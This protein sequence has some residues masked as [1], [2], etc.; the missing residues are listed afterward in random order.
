MERRIKKTAIF[1]SLLLFVT[2]R[3]NAQDNTE[4]IKLSEIIVTLQK[5]YNIQFNYAEDVIAGISLKPPQENLSLLEVL[6]YLENNTTLKFSLLNSSFV[7]VKPRNNIVLCGY[8]KSED[9]LQI[10]PF[11]TI[12][13]LN[14]STTSDKNGFFQIEINNTSQLITIRHLGYKTVTQSYNQFNISGCSDVYL[15]PEFQPLPQIIISNYITSGINKINNGSF[16]INFSDLKIL[17]GLINNDVLQAVQT[18]PGIQSINETVSNINIR[19]G[20]HD[21]NLILWDGIKMYQSGHFFGLISMYNP[22]ITQEVSLRKNGSDVS[23]TDGVSGTI[24]MHTNHEINTEFKGV[25]DLNLTDFNGFADFPVGERSSVQVAARKSI[26]DF[27]ETPTYTAFFDRI[28]Q[29]TEVESNTTAIAN[30]DKTFDFYDTSLRWLYNISAKDKVRLNFINV[31]NQLQFN[32]NAII[33]Q[34]VVSRNSKLT[35]NSIAGALQYNRLWNNKLS[36]DLEIYETD[37]KLQAV[38]ANILDSQ[39]FLQENIV[40]ETSVKVKTNYKLNNGL[41]LLSGYH[42]VETKVTNLDDVDNPLYRFL[43]S[44]VI[45]THGVFSQAG[46]TTKDSRTHLNLG[47]RYNYIG[48]FNTSIWEPRFSFNH[49]FLKD[50]TLEILGEFKHQNTSQVINFQNDFLGIEKRRWQLA[51]N[52]DIPIIMSKQVSIGLDYSHKGWLIGLDGFYK[53]VDGI[54]TQSQGFQNQFEFIKTHGRYDVTGID[55]LFRKHIDRFNGWLSYSYMKNRYR[56]KALEADYFP[57]NYDVSHTATLGVIY[58]LNN[59]RLSSGV[60][61]HSGKPTTRPVFNNQIMNSKINYEAT[62]TSNLNDYL[63]LDISAVYNFKFKGKTQANLGISIWNVLDKE[64][65]IN[66]FYRLEGNNIM[67]TVQKSLGF[68]PNAV[69]RV[70]F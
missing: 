22:H 34:E 42:F 10:L 15:L 28:S 17:P 12:Q 50:F 70:Y 65:E 61:W 13:T 64:N 24:E 69:F 60:N 33:N 47:L 29:N 26:S 68:T 66:N 54:T 38:N 57:S 18:F 16:Q 2:I 4:T 56:F 23:Y 51:N 41:E 44:E 20:T 30:T 48:K 8:L 39:R 14:R 49:E 52:E 53:V 19:G 21:Q 27:F 6:T 5:V 55:V 36:T 37:Y 25:I 1:F 31:H 67:E 3:V 59:L 35:Q 11:A 63:R 7:L 58:I 46:Y 43:V 45:R 32:E 40:S 9:D 62:N